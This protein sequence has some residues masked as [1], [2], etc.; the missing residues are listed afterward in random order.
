MNRASLSLMP[1]GGV[2]EIGS[3]H[4]LLRSPSHDV[5][6]DC[7][8]LFPYEDFFDINYLVPDFGFIDPARLR[9]IVI[10]HGHEDHIG[11]LPHLLALFPDVPVH[12]SPFTQALIRRRCEEAGLSPRLVTFRAGDSIDFGEF[13]IH[14]VH[15]TH[16]IPE[17]FGLFVRDQERQWGLF[18]ASDF[19]YDLNPGHEA[20]FD[21]AGLQ[22]LASTVQKTAFFIDSTNALVPG[23]TPSEQ[24]L[25]DDL[26]GVIASGSERLF[27][28]LF[29]S[30]V[31]RMGRI[32]TLAQRHGR[33]IVLMGRS[34]EHY[35]RAGAETGI[36]P[37]TV[38]DFFQPIQVKGQTGRMLIVVSGCQGDYMSALRRLAAGEDGTF[39][40]A[41][42]DKVVFSSKVIPGND[43]KIARI[44]N[45]IVE[46]GAEVVT[47]HDRLIHASGHPAQEDLVALA[48]ELRPNVWFPI[49][50]ESFFLHRHHALMRERFPTMEGAV[51]MNWHEV[52]F[53]PG[54]TW[55]IKEHPEREPVLIHGRGLPIERTQISQRR[56]MACQGSI[57]VS[58][59]RVR[60]NCH[61]SSLGLPLSTKDC[62]ARVRGLI[63]EKVREDLGSRAPE[64]AADQVK[65]LVRQYFQQSLGY[66]PV[67]EVHIL[68]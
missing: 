53:H 60:G 56:K 25:H 55:R 65:I 63:L 6:V 2:G 26:E 10:T 48:S 52:L 14:P 36:L 4:T 19:K 23:K 31:H 5:I 46:A 40:L 28:T 24:E 16:S 47:A 3:N 33:K 54:G 1:A 62:M 21:V 61:V 8:L 15:V 42:G 12:A 30:N 22:S 35:A 59:D 7:G 50:G 17:T 11:A 9:A 67:T 44:I 20:P 57:F 38:D 13:S 34:V 27:I 39:K 41:P 18:Y 51:I 49:H 45:Q 58:I 37:F 29:S 43:K 66:K 32:F 68:S 64:Y